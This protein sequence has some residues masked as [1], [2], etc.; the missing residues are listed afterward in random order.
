[1]RDRLREGERWVRLITGRGLHSRG[2]PV[3]REE[4]EHLLR[5]LSGSLVRRV[6][7]ESGGGALRVELQ[8]PQV[9]S[10]LSRRA[11]IPGASPEL[12]REAEEALA[13]LGITPTPELLAAEI[14]RIREERRTPP[15]SP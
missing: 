2:R 8:S 1:M 6:E 14:R 9:P 7:V 11:A 3:L 5:E 12:R 10:A 13:E 15:S 4:I